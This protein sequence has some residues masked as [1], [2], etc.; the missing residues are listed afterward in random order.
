[1]HLLDTSRATG[2]SF[3]NKVNAF[4]TGLL[5][6]SHFDYQYIGNLD[7]DISLQ[8]NYFETI[9]TRFEK[10]KQLGIGG[11]MVSTS[12]AGQF[13]SQDVANDSVAGAVQ[14]FRRACFEQIGGYLPLRQG[15]IDA[16][17]EI[18]ARMHGWKVQTFS[19]LRVLEHR[20]T[21]SAVATPLSAKVNEGLRSQSLGYGF[22]F[23]LLR[24]IYR[25]TTPPVVIG[26]LATLYGYLKGVLS[27]NPIVLSPDV[28]RYLRNEQRQKLWRL[29]G[30]VH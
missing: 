19:D 22:W 15:G 7:A 12:I 16:A 3:S 9:M 21:G 26:S 10:N 14:F 8:S 5:F 25:L 4:N 1:M 23:M 24:C 30:R 28:V 27:Q 20:R 11:G 13:V 29:I 2:R 6:A 18:L 17:A